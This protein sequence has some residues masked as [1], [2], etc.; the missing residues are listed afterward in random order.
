M[1]RSELE[2][3]LF[4]L[5]SN[6]VKALDRGSGATRRLRVRAVPSKD[7]TQVVIS[8]QDSGAGIDPSI[9]H[10]IFEP[11]VTSSTQLS[12]ELGTGTGLGLTV[13][14]DLIESYGGSAR[15]GVPDKDMTTSIEIMLPRS[16]HQSEVGDRV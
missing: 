8:F 14:R 16:S 4:N 13:V 10:Q 15:I 1:A 11:F 7:A 9:A 6:A 2:A 5:L 3:V 12:P